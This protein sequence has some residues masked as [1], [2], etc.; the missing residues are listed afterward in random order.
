V[1]ICV[2][3]L[4]YS[5]FQH[6]TVVDL[7]VVG[8]CLFCFC[9]KAS[10]IV[11]TNCISLV[12]LAL[13][14]SYAISWAERQQWVDSFLFSRRKL[15]RYRRANAH[16]NQFCIS[17]TDSRIDR[18][19]FIS[20]FK[21]LLQ[22]Y[23]MLPPRTALREPSLGY[24]EARGRT[25]ILDAN[26]SHALRCPAQ[27][28]GRFTP[29]TQLGRYFE[30]RVVPRT[31]LPPLHAEAWRQASTSEAGMDQR[32]RPEEWEDPAW[33]WM[34]KRHEFRS[35]LL[36]STHVRGRG[37]RPARMVRVPDVTVHRTIVAAYC[38]RHTTCSG[39]WYVNGIEIAWTVCL[40]QGGWW[41]EY[42]SSYSDAISLLQ[43]PQENK[44]RDVCGKAE[45]RQ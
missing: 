4:H 34:D 24:L 39:D 7:C 44:Q 16:I 10:W 33:S 32:Q 3:F 2:I 19:Y 31:W 22:Y 26:W 21:R 37:I 17:M 14:A 27:S 41:V 38:K 9:L 40:M 23:T 29:S 35:P 43:P 28:R 30:G 18:S 45:G 42:A 20:N 5:C 8:A 12:L 15:G 11:T 1:V 6:P 36:D 13:H 25:P